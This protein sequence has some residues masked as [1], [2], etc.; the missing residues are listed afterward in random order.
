[1]L[2]LG[3]LRKL[4]L[5]ASALSFDLVLFSVC[6][7]SIC[8]NRKHIKKFWPGQDYALDARYPRCLLKCT[9][10]TLA[11]S[12]GTLVGTASWGIQ[13]GELSWDPNEGR[14]M[15]QKQEG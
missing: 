8:H 4:Q 15:G 9:P 3:N 10:S 2:L 5:S 6:R 12:W 7:V 1:M 14:G 13:G 11:K